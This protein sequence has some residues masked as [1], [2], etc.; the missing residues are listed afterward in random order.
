MLR[1][2]LRSKFVRSLAI[3][4]AIGLILPRERRVGTFMGVPY[5]VRLPTLTRIRERL[6]NKED[7][8]IFTP[9]VFGGGWSVNL[10]AV[11]KKLGLLK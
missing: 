3:T 7:P 1:R 4:A 11:G 10:Y 9:R 6:W 2:L 8:R 5:D